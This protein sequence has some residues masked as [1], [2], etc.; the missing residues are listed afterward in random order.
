MQCNVERPPQRKHHKTVL[1]FIYLQWHGMS[2]QDIRD[3]EDATKKE[4]EE[5]RA[6]GEVRGKIVFIGLSTTW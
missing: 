2:V 1:N 6:T 3:L 5:L 4:L